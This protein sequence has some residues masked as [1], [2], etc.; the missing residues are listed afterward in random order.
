MSMSMAQVALP[1]TSLVNKHIFFFKIAL[2]YNKIINILQYDIKKS[3]S[4]KE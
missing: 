4:P 1:Q 2:L 3:S